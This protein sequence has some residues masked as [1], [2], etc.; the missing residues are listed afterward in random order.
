MVDN[1][2]RLFFSKY[3]LQI[4]GKAIAS[5]QNGVKSAEEEA[6]FDKFFESY[7]SSH[8]LTLAYPDEILLDSARKAGIK[9]E[10]REKSEIVKELF[11]T[12]ESQ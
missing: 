5:F 10:G 9:T 8:A 4:A 7:E 3:L 6:N 11:K 1:N 12:R 2:K